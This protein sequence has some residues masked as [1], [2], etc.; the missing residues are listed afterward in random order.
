MGD[1]EGMVF[2]LPTSAE[3][4]RDLFAE[5][6][7]NL[8][9]GYDDFDVDEFLM[10][11]N[12]QYVQLDSLISD[13]SNLS[14]EVVQALLSQVSDRYDDYMSFCKTFAGD[15]SETMM[16]LQRTRE[17]LH[18]F[19]SQLEQ[20]ASRD[21]P[22]TK[23]VVN[24]AIEYLQKIDEIV[25]LLKTHEDLK[26]TLSVAKQLSDSLHH[27]CGNDDID[28]KICNELTVRLHSL[29]HNSNKLLESLS[30]LDSPYVRHMRNEYHSLIQTFQIA[31][32]LLTARC[33]EDPKRYPLLSKT[34]IAILAETKA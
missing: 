5:E 27:L 13:V 25:S 4:N 14:R 29:V 23:E 30:T 28:E 19:M 21:I 20:L 15:D 3:V 26:E 18:Q 16:E 34:L 32:K 22:R 6:V 7:E 33:L 2:D 11:N 1:E 31:L 24:D 17:D 12:F 10:R 8:K 9:G